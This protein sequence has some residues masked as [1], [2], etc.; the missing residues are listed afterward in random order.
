ML[1]G[2]LA[3]LGRGY[4]TPAVTVFVPPPQGASGEIQ[5]RIPDLIL[6]SAQP[7]E[8]FEAGTPPELVIEVLSTRR[9]NVERTEKLDDYARAG[10]GEYWIVDPFERA[11]EVY[12]LDRGDFTLAQTTQ[13]LHPAAFPGL[14]IDR[15]EVWTA[16]D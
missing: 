3:V 8:A 7:K 6:H 4:V 2:K 9:G 10:I 15:R 16:L 14:Q 5:S 12:R 11:V 13:T 1:E